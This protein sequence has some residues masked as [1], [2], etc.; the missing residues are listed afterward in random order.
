[1][2]ANYKFG[3]FELRQDAQQLLV[4][5]QPAP[6]GKRAFDILRV[7][8]ERRGALVTK[9]ELLDLVWPGLVVEE[10][11]LQVQV[12][13]LRKILG[14]DAI[15]TV[16][17][18]GYRFTPQVDAGALSHPAQILERLPVA[19]VA[20]KPSIAMLPFVN[21][22]GDAGNEYF[23]DGLSEELLNVLSKIRGLRVASR[24]SA[25]SFKGE[26][27]DIAT[28]AQKLNVATIL[29]GSVR[30]SGNRV[31]ISVQLI[32]VATDSHLWSASYD[33][34]L[35]DIFAVQDDI[36][37]SVV[38]EL[39][40]ALMGEEPSAD[41]SGAVRFE[42]EAA[43]RGRGENAE[44]YRLYL[45]ASFHNDRVTAEDFAIAI[46]A[47][48]AAL[49]LDPSYALAWA[50][51]SIAYA[52]GT[53]QD[54]LPTD[55][56]EGFRLAREAAAQA[57]RLA[58][59][60]AESH[61]ALGVI[62]FA[63][64]WDWKGAEASF[65]RALELAPHSIRIMRHTTFMLLAR[66]RYDE[67][68]ALLR[69]AV[70]LDPLSGALH[71]F[72]ARIYRIAG[73]LDQ[74]ETAI[75]KSLELSAHAGFAHYYY[76]D[77]CLARGRL[78]EALELAKREIHETFRLLALA[79]VYHAQGQHTESD[80][81]LEQLIDNHADITAFQ[82]AEAFAYRGDRDRAFEWLERARAQ[83]DAGMSMV[84]AVPNLCSLHGDRRWKP[85][86][87]IVGLAD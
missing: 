15:A 45:Q 20:D 31:R 77:I 66:A 78:D 26:K 85:F 71:G 12:S 47:Y 19:D 68:I 2:T 3:R 7:L 27:V 1:M 52:N 16:A 53:A 17:G 10:N 60:L 42:V 6:L 36:A 40:A 75:R 18:R 38:K 13:A 70:E 44:A 76:S 28:M 82:I 87:E 46:E 43:A 83:R 33:R 61:E 39:R 55:L 23:A 32:H 81:A 5:D 56:D 64:D 35:E 80:A 9:D 73:R 48:K 58:P 50:G 4:D 37:Q 54:W 57:M 21:T 63:N 34:Q 24:T 41:T 79:N 14:N 29:E 25:F 65:A 86:I 59:D 49:K 84:R 51:L 22:S 62:R 72:L 8:I 30:K 69:R 11:N 67:A 74:A